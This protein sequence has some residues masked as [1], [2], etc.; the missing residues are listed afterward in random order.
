MILGQSDKVLKRYFTTIR[1]IFHVKQLLNSLTV[2]KKEAVSTLKR[3]I[4]V[5]NVKNFWTFRVE[6]NK[7]VAFA[8]NKEIC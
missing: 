7:C 8:S 3:I 6:N 1:G 2:E 5:M 4:G